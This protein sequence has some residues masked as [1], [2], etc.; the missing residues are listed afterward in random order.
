MCRPS[1]ADCFNFYIPGLTP[2]AT[3]APPLRRYY[4]KAP[5]G[6]ILVVSGAITQNPGG[7]I[8]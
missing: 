7:V 3:K 8:S 4:P 1:G 2:R 5:E 6:G